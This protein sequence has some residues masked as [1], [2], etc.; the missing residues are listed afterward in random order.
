MKYPPREGD[1]PREELVKAAERETGPDGQ[2]PGAT[3][4]FKF[5]CE[6]CGERCLLQVENTLF[7]KGECCV[8]GKETEIK[9]GGFLVH[10]SPNPGLQIDCEN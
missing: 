6:H 1:L 3:V 2:W 4:V 8:C 7:E 9:F 5:T 10:W